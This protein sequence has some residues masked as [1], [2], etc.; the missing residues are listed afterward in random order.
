MESWLDGTVTV[1]RRVKNINIKIGKVP[2][3]GS[4]R[5]PVTWQIAEVKMGPTRAE[6]GKPVVFKV[7]SREIKVKVGEFWFKVRRAKWK[8]AM[9]CTK[10]REME[11]HLGFCKVLNRNRC[12]VRER[13]QE[14]A[15]ELAREETCAENV[16]GR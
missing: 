13:R 14:T 2:V 8:A 5:G 12:Y 1:K 10:I 3:K 6:S 9:V 7:D 11:T 4:N 15:S 16:R